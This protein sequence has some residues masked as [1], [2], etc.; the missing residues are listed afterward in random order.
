MAIAARRVLLVLAFALLLQLPC[1]SFAASNAP[2]DYTAMDITVA[3]KSGSQSQVSISARMI[4][5]QSNDIT[6]D[7]LIQSIKT[8][9]VPASQIE[10]I[11]VTRVVAGA[12]I[13]FY[14]ETAD[15]STMLCANK[16]TDSNGQASCD[17]SVS[18][19]GCGSIVARFVGNAS[20]F[21]SEVPSVYCTSGVPPFGQIVDSGWIAVFIVL[22]ALAAALYAS[23]REPLKA[24]D[25][26]TPR[27]KG[28]SSPK[29]YKFAKTEVSGLPALAASAI[30]A[31][32]LTSQSRNMNSALDTAKKYM[33]KEE[34][35]K[36]IKGLPKEMDKRVLLVASVLKESGVYGKLSHKAMITQKSL[37][38]LQRR[39]E[40]AKTRE[41]RD[42][43]EGQIAKAASAI[44]QYESDFERL[45]P[46]NLPDGPDLI[47]LK[48]SEYAKL[49]HEADKS[50]LSAALQQMSNPDAE[51]TDMFQD[52][53]ESIESSTRSE[54]T[55]V[56]AGF[57]EKLASILISSASAQ[58]VRF[59]NIQMAMRKILASL[60][61]G[62]RDLDDFIKELNDPRTSLDRK[63]ELITNLLGKVSVE[64]AKTFAERA[65]VSKRVFGD[66]THTQDQLIQRLSALE[67]A[68]AAMGTKGGLFA[69][70]ITSA[71]YHAF[72]NYLMLSRKASDYAS[73]LT[74]E[75]SALNEKAMPLKVSQ[76]EAKDIA[77]Q[78]MRQLDIS[79]L[80]VLT[81]RLK[82]KDA[83]QLEKDFITEWGKHLV[84][85][86]TE[87]L[88]T[89]PAESRQ[90]LRD[91]ID[92]IKKEF[93]GA[94]QAMR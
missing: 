69:D 26:T 80:D 88:K 50:F 33:S 17:V 63:E 32:G 58:R 3:P 29:S 31:A 91:E 89:A 87:S 39:R 27:T 67:A 8:G 73:Q 75:K 48:R 4:S 5:I 52:V 49:M 65:K 24:F 37:N 71:Q 76:A 38:E 20:L 79:A 1:V 2:K 16:T 22:G 57:A 13:S 45:S 53:K 85:E 59:A 23:G 25:V 42:E 94:G 43:I 10:N 68:L 70:R 64:D 66:L 93:K 21:G 81:S 44:K 36:M 77:E 92:R 78:I 18:S 9:V 47:S 7:Q 46:K 74:D 11:Y 15:K 30:A 6:S 19:F 60:K 86:R 40:A 28:P 54:L 72:I 84:Q 12:N 35:D 41:E 14:F 51:S 61:P 82:S 55:G 90:V 62:D 83:G 56:S 34:Y